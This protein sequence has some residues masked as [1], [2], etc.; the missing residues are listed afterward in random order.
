MLELTELRDRRDAVMERIAGAA[1]RAGRDAAEITLVAVTKTWPAEL[2]IA[3]HAIGLR[4]FGE[5]RPEELAVKRPIVETVL[6]VDNG[7]TWHLIGPVQSRKSDLAAA[8][9]DVFHA[10]DR[11]KIA[12][13]LSNDL[14]RFGRTLPSFIEVN[15]SGE[16]TKHGFNLVNWENDATQRNSLRTMIRKTAELPGLPVMGLMTMAPWDAERDLIRSVFHR[17]RGI[18]DWLL[19][20]GDVSHA[21]YLS[22]GM[23]DDFEIAIEEGATHVRVGRA[24]FGEREK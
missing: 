19:A 23:T 18:A 4:H 2:V 20:E 24:L 21:L 14:V 9:A 13:R 16:A 6:G 15:V 8:H 17:T 3:A 1:A 5:N 10:L 11:S 7:I 12:H 22:M